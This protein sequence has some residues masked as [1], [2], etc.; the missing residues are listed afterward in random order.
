MTSR[1]KKPFCYFT[2]ASDCLYI[3]FYKPFAVLTQFSKEPGTDKSTLADFGFPPHIYPLGRL[4]FDSEGL[5]LLSDDKRLNGVLL[6]PKHMHSRTYLAQVEN[7]PTK[8]QLDTLSKGVNIQGHRTSPATV[9]LL[10]HKPHLPD[11]PV[12]I[13]FRK[14][15]PTAWLE[16]NLTEGRNRQVR[17]MTAAVGCPTLRLLR[18]AI[19][20]LKLA[21]LAI[22]PGEWTVLSGDQLLLSLS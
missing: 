20:Q 9:R 7:I 3:A 5:L 1:D 14:N 19:G 4:D 15:I 2:P 22:N 10:E 13:R 8:E 6:N 17:R 18:I 12:P 21:D 16:L 11:R